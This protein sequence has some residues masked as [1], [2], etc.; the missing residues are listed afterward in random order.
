M[1]R[2]IPG[3][4]KHRGKS[5][6][7]RLRKTVKLDRHSRRPLF[8]ELEDRRLLA[9]NFTNLAS[10]LDSQLT[11][12][13]TQ[14]TSTLNN[15][16]TGPLSSIPLVGK[17][18]GSAAQIVSSFSTQLK[19]GLA[20]LGTLSNPTDSQIQNALAGVPLLVNG[21]DGVIVTR[22]NGPASETFAVQMRLQRAATPAGGSFSFNTG[23]PSLPLSVATSGTIDVS[24]GFAFELA[25]TYNSTNQQVTLDSNKN[26]SGLAA[27]DGNHPIVDPLHPLAIF[28]SASP[29][30]GFSASA[31]LGFVK[32]TATPIAGQANAL[33]L[34]V[35][36]N[37]LTGA[38]TIKLDG[39]AD[40]NLRLTGGFTGTN[41]DFPA[42][43]ADFHLHWSFSSNNPTANPPQVTVDNVALNL[44]QFLGNVLKPVFEVIQTTTAPMKPLEELFRYP[45]PVLSD[46]SHL[47]GRGN[48]TLLDIADIV[49]P[50]TEYGPLFDLIRSMSDLVYSINQID[51]STSLKMPLG[52]FD[53]NNY[54]LRGV[55]SAG[56]VHDL[57][58][59]NLTDFA[60]ANV[61]ATNLPVPSE[62]TQFL[63]KLVATMS[64]G[65][66]IHF[67]IL[68]DPK[69]AVFG[70]LLGRDSDLFTFTADYTFNSQGSE[71]PSFSV[72]GM[73]VKFGG[74]VHMQAHFK[75]AYDTFGLRQLLNHLAD[76]NTADVSGD[77]IAGF[78]IADDS[79]F[80]LK[81]DLFAGVGARV[82]IFSAD[83]GGFVKT[84]NEGNDPVSITINDPNHDGKL[85]FAE[86]SNGGLRTSGRFVAAIGIEVGVGFVE[87]FFGEFIGWKKRF[88]IASTV[89]VDLNMPDPN[90]PPV[91]TGPIL[92]SQP[93]ENGTVVL[94]V[95]ASA[96]LRQEVDQ[97]NGDEKIV[98][99]NIE[100][101]DAGETIEIAMLRK[102]P[103]LDIEYWATQKITG[104][105]AITGYG[106]LG[107]LVIDVLPGVNVNVEFWGGEGKTEFLYNGAGSASLH[108]GQG[109]A[110][111]IG[112][113]GGNILFGG[114]GNDT[115][116]L[117]PGGNF[118]SGG[119]GDNSFIIS[120]PLTDGGVIFGGSDEG[121]NTFVV[122]AG[123]GTQWISAMPGVN[124]SIDLHYQIV[125]APPSPGLGLRQF[126]TLVISAQDRSTDITIGDLSSA[127]VSQVIVS[128]P[129]TGDGGRNITLD[130]KANSG[131]SQI[132]V[133]PFLHTHLNPD[134]D[135]AIPEGPAN[136]LMIQNNELQVVNVTTGVTT[137][138]FGMKDADLT[139]I[140][141]HGGSAQ[142]GQLSK[143]EGA[144]AFDFSTRPAGVVQTVSMTTPALAAGNLITSH[145]N[146]AND[147]VLDVINYP[148][149]VFH[150][151][152]TV[153]SI[154]ANVAA[155]TQAAG[156]N[157]VVLDASSLVGT[158]NVD[159]LGG[160]S[161]HDVVTISKL[162]SGGTVAVHGGSTSTTAYFGTGRLADI[163]GNVS[164]NNTVLTIDNHLAQGTIFN[165][166]APGGSIFAMTGTT[167][168]GWIIPAFAGNPALTYSGL[169]G[170]LTV[171][172]GADDQF[173]LDGTPASITSAVF[174][175]ATASRNAV[176][177][178]AW[179]KPLTLNG[180]FSLYLGERRLNG[181]AVQRV[182][183]LTGLANV[184]ITLNFSTAING[185]TDIAF[186]GD[187]D[188]AGASYTIDGIGN[189]HVVNQ[190][191]GLS[192]TINGYRDQDSIHLRLPGG[193]V[194]VNLTETGRGTIYVDGTARSSGINPTAANNIAAT[195]RAG[196]QTLDPNASTDSVLHA[197]DTLYV[198]GAQVQDDLSLNLPTVAN[199]TNT[200][201]AD[202][203]QLVGTLHI[204]ALD[205][206]PGV[207][208]PFGLTT[209]VLAAVNPLLAV[210]VV[211]NNP[212][213]GSSTYQ[214]DQT[215]LA[216][217][218][219]QLA[220]I[221]GNVTTSKVA[222]KIDDSSAAQPSD[223]LL[224]DTTFRNWIIPGSSL[225]PTLTYSNLYSTLTAYAGAGDRLDLNRTPAGVTDLV[226]HNVTTTLDQVYTA[227]WTVPVAL[228]G[229]FSFYAGRRLV[230]D[231]LNQ[232]QMATVER[233][234]RLTDVAVPVTLNF[235]GMA[236][237]E[238]VLDGDLE[239]AGAQYTIDGAGNL[240]VVNQTVGL[241]V[242]I[243][244][245][246]DQDELHLRLPGATVAADL[247]KTG[248][249][250]IL[251]D[252][253]E[254]LDGTN[255][256]APNDFSV[257]V[258]AG[259]ISL[260]AVDTNDSL[261]Y[262]A[263]KVYVLASMPQDSLSVTAPT[264]FKLAPTV[265]GQSPISYG[266]F[267]GFYFA[268]T[269]PAG[270]FQ[271]ISKDFGTTSGHVETPILTTSPLQNGEFD[272]YD[273]TL[274][275]VSDHSPPLSGV[276][277]IRVFPL[278]S[279]PVTTDNEVNLDA[280]QLRG[281]LHFQV[282]EPD[283]AWALQLKQAMESWVAGV[284]TTFG[285]TTV[286][287]A[288]ANP[289]LS[290]TIT[291]TTAPS[292]ANYNNSNTSN[293]SVVPVGARVIQYPGTIV[294]IGAGVLTDIRGHVSVDKVWLKEIDDR[295]GTQPNVLTLTSTSLA[296]MGAS[297]SL[298]MQQLFGDLTITGSPFDRF[299]VEGTP[300]TASK[301]TIRNFATSQPP[302]GVYVMAKTVMPLEVTGNF[303]LYVGQ[304]LNAD[305][306]VTAVGQVSGVFDK[307]DQYH[308][309]TL[310]SISKLYRNLMPVD[311]TSAA[312][313][314]TPIR[315]LDGNYTTVLA[316]SQQRQLPV[317]YTYTG[318]G[319]GKLVFDASGEQITGLASDFFYNPGQYYHGIST[320]NLY[321]GMADLRFF[322]GSVIYGPNAEVFV[323]G[324]KLG[325]NSNLRNPAPSLLI[326]NPFATA[327]HYIANPNNTIANVVEEVIIG[328]VNGPVYVEGN[329]G[330]TRV[331]LNPL[332]SLP[333]AF[334]L[335]NAPFEA[336][337]IFPGWGRGHTG[338]FSLMDTVHA[339]VTVAN[340]SFR[341]IAD[342]PLPN[343]S[344]PVASRPN[345]TLTGTEL[346]GIAG[347][348]IHFSNLVN[349][350]SLLDSSNQRGLDIARSFANYMPGLSVQL[351]AHAAVSTTVADTPA[352]TTSVISTRLSASETA[353][354]DGP[355]TVE[356]TTGPLVLGQLF[357][358][359]AFRAD[360]VDFRL[361]PLLASQ[362]IGSLQWGDGLSVPQVIIGDEGSLQN[363]HGPI[364]L[365]GD[366][367]NNSPIV[368][369]I[370]G[371]AD[372]SRSNV[373]FTQ[374]TY[375]QPPSSIVSTVVN[376]GLG[377]FYTQVDGLA[378]AP[379]YFGDFFKRPHALEI[380][381]SAGS[382]YN[383]TGST[384]AGAPPTMK[385]YAGANSS[386]VYDSGLAGPLSII[387]ATSVQLVLGRGLTD[388][389]IPDY[390]GVTQI[391][392]EQD[393]SHLQPIDLRLDYRS[394]ATPTP[395]TTLLLNNAGVDVM[396]LSLDSPASG[397]SGATLWW[398]VRY[399]GAETHLDVNYARP[400]GSFGPII[401][402]DTGAG[403]TVINNGNQTV[404]VFGTTGPLRINASGSTSSALVR[405]GQS[406]NMQAIIGEVEIRSNAAAPLGFT[407]LT[408]N[409]SADTAHR[410]IHLTTDVDG[411][412]RITGMAPGLVKLVGERFTPTL[413][414]GTGSSTWYID[415]AIFPQ[416]SQQ[417]TIVGGATADLLVGPDLP[418]TWTM[419]A[420]NSVLLRANVRAN[421]IRNLLGGADTDLFRSM[422]SSGTIAGDL[423][424]GGGFNTL[425]YVTI[426]NPFVTDLVGGSAPRIGGAVRKIHAVIPEQLSFVA[427]SILSHQ[428]GANV[429]V[430]LNANSTVGG[431][432]TYGASGLPAGLSIN[433][434]TGLI[435]GSV[436][437]G[438]ELHGPYQ[439]T[440]T[441]TNGANSRLRSI[442]WNVSALLPGDF[443]QD[444]MVNAADYIVWR[445]LS[446]S[447]DAYS[448][449]RAS[450]GNV[451]SPP[452]SGS[453]EIAV[454]ESEEVTLKT[455]A[456]PSS[457][458]DIADS[459]G[460]MGGPMP[461]KAQSYGAD[462]SEMV[463]KQ[464]H[465][466]TLRTRR[467]AVDWL[468]HIEA[469]PVHRIA[470]SMSIFAQ[471][472]VLKEH[473]ITAART[474]LKDDALA[475]WVISRFDDRVVKESGLKMSKR[476]ETATDVDE[477]FLTAIDECFARP[478]F[479]LDPSEGK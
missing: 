269:P 228:N 158:L 177:M 349:S 369:R 459:T 472:T 82:A 88:D 151:L 135:P 244:G 162:A 174:N 363:I 33:N 123:E 344:T 96:H 179:T 204:N 272:Y 403:G 255:P 478:L 197:F 383:I 94:Y 463:L 335:V 99:R 274:Q 18:L 6:R 55:P 155:P 450:F 93:D 339:D 324:P 163:R 332:F 288:K 165:S 167:F 305:G 176:Y 278:N 12:M 129:T 294:T 116:V 377:N 384:T 15:Y 362:P 56:D 79:H 77:I 385:L 168:S 1:F 7:R 285:Q 48:V 171:N 175:N 128:I 138:L 323:N 58:L 203:S 405:L 233:V 388:G 429:S 264:T 104:V 24:V 308:A 257:L 442:D 316:S 418:N 131:T 476:D 34:T 342:I 273:T 366:S 60:I 329:G 302:V 27:P 112:G 85:R 170:A 352:G 26:L 380:Y 340:A 4:T 303:D 122:L 477:G 72:Y 354:T 36:A 69:A 298:T 439:V 307:Q 259:Q 252:G 31:T 144:L 41:D 64:N 148:T 105:R 215:T 110:Y 445:K 52:G 271:V 173:T 471:G 253:N 258:R 328:N 124:G 117:G 301:T 444:L 70:M 191:L 198:V 119:M 83:V 54:D 149:L 172:T 250:T 193:S 30:A 205:P 402:S 458:A 37:N 337:M 134:F 53:L 440:V 284:V 218:A 393:P 381:G 208:S 254:R 432:L 89:I 421:N 81:G 78:Y 341:V 392:V 409:N 319:Q 245:Y 49:A 437:A 154:T 448:V 106:D 8:E 411:N 147:F 74:D 139:T 159:A 311:F 188:P 184:P 419:D 449:W 65:Y 286:V 42:I 322:Q 136:P 2:I 35:M 25:F 426:P 420:T 130:T 256:T 309:T 317:F 157:Y 408:L 227:N 470:S 192:V 61:Q 201:T 11:G 412:T 100:T 268:V 40:A 267:F 367:H 190:T 236:V 137:Y 241:S 376:S 199:T 451:M 153:D 21:A 126:S 299:A 441:V 406:N 246:R 242:T 23:L 109:D 331:E 142:I 84:D 80:T 321:P 358:P 10:S 231:D 196:T 224:T 9:V 237:S 107:D 394:A 370:D 347:S 132:I 118:V 396:S 44:G 95:G 423:D 314:P 431:T 185:G 455:S 379:I 166:A 183:H 290:T 318:A 125:D 200:F 195:L 287:M 187:L 39:V 156:I 181:G 365:S 333:I 281:T 226:M 243:N 447:Q 348:T 436:A 382:S 465:I 212:F 169:H 466:R 438:A 47:I 360:G 386:A 368:T 469:S 346:L 338:D 372:S 275:Y 456:P 279:N 229:H 320:N 461:T 453:A 98:I 86:F 209:I 330:A 180:D 270:F 474:S 50:Y 355:I 475:E 16:Q 152:R 160:S 247:R 389:S 413:T 121:H 291:G 351:P 38:P 422:N 371:R 400:G 14:L 66:E 161:V 473:A 468:F 232:E 146:A 454:A 43:D 404:D 410:D 427:P 306:S 446:G 248:S 189:M 182:Q 391:Y 312:L 251:L 73:G 45:L 364:L 304:R 46:L 3:W 75:F 102:L 265:Q 280:S 395:D 213:P 178:A 435:S 266:Y 133:D 293:G 51:L 399:P 223:L 345:V 326:D 164:I 378:S 234:R 353:M 238:V 221:R 217:G 59:K 5:T 111:L 216:F 29:S 296:W 71:L 261:L 97:I 194:D 92:A 350:I 417:L 297:A 401:V 220:R 460:R 276:A 416:S 327:V 230:I 375:S 207:V 239:P 260:D 140:R 222:L 464:D 479:S 62:A 325:T 452:G 374:P 398:T 115:I 32:G 127:G 263:N 214:V 186:D 283:Y 235:S 211:G 336:F 108:A 430:Q 390:S 150:G 443:N 407:T 219:G 87:P 90:A 19:S 424:G 101:T 249:G 67:P 300:N 289:Q 141:Q 313:L 428:V 13:Q 414:G 262:A 57:N 76:G 295:Q 373:S 282:A 315:Y 467:P 145:A 20:G 277:Q 415:S 114:P 113:Q 210:F 343:G 361:Y 91:P 387:G 202:A 292:V 434:A 310:P 17:S 240:R 397:I 63:Q 103:I 120:T 334:S 357:G 462:S 425:E 206:L 433:L 68:D 143:N 22:P 356:G 359:V 28:V 457:T 225:R